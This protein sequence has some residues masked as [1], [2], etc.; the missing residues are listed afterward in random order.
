MNTATKTAA[1]KEIKPNGRNN[2]TAQV[3]KKIDREPGKST[4]VE[5]TKPVEK[6]TP[7]IPIVPELTVEQKIQKVSNDLIE[8]RNK[9]LDAGN[10]LE[11]FDL[12]RENHSTNIE[13]SDGNGNLFSTYN[14]DAVKTFIAATKAQIASE[15]ASVEEKIQF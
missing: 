7:V 9:L 6:K 8:K 14:P 1:K 4:P 5:E 11:S 10:K 2:Q 15:L 12:K 13:L 3:N